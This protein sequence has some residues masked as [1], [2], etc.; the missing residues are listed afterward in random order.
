M[1][2]K[3]NNPD[4]W[5]SMWEEALNSSQKGRN[6]N[7]DLGVERW[8]SRARQFAENAT[9]P[10]T[11]DKTE[12][13]LGWLIQAGALKAGF[14]VLD[15]GAGSGRYAIP[16]ALMGCQVVA[17]E[18]AEAMVEHMRERMTQENI[19]NI[20]ILNKTWQDINLDQDKMRGQFDLVF[21]SMTPGIQ[22]PD[23]LM[24]MIGASRLA[25]Y[26]SGH[27]KDRWRHLEKLW[28]VIYGQ[29][30]PETPGDF[31]YRFG[32]VYAMGY[33]P[34]T[35]YLRGSGSRKGDAHSLEM[36]KKDILWS[37][38]GRVGEDELTDEIFAKI[39]AYVASLNL[40]SEVAAVDR[41]MASQAML[42]FV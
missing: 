32:L 3:L 40:E 27:T 33:M 20:T 4:T 24:K 1:T 34:L 25:C 26:L 14:R 28:R 6:K 39:D 16:M 8:N 2:I 36:I 13:L 5:T 31:L 29:D 30:M 22:A 35:Y 19:T 41:G 11:Q 15:L 10:G 37:L 38:S 9:K 7:E 42:W 23:D 12:E 18:P 17:L 21:A